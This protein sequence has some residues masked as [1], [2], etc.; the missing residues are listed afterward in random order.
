MA[1]G[2]EFRQV[3]E[4]LTTQQIEAVRVNNV[5]LVRRISL[6]ILIL[7]TDFT[8]EAAAA[9]VQ[10]LI[11]GT[12]EL[13][14]D[15]SDVLQNELK[16]GIVDSQLKIIRFGKEQF[17][18][19]LNDAFWKTLEYFFQNP[20]YKLDTMPLIQ[21][22]HFTNL[23]NIYNH[24]SGINKA[25]QQAGLAERGIRISKTGNAVGVYEL[26]FP[27]KR[28]VTEASSLPQ[29]QEQT[30]E[31]ISSKETKESQIT[32]LILI[33]T[34]VCDQN[35]QVL[36]DT[37]S[38]KRMAILR[39]LLERAETEVS[40]EELKEKLGYANQHDSNFSSIFSRLRTEIK[41]ASL[42]SRLIMISD[43]KRQVGTSRAEEK[44]YLLRILDPKVSIAL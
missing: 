18:L 1:T 34:T 27:G 3:I 30:S 22:G 23:S 40:R 35:H 5:E 15:F 17:R 29:V 25:L 39:Y 31:G 26:L 44:F 6:V 37:R 33:G 21:S 36:F 7:T 38:K 13:G 10:M 11:I 42:L 9:L 2:I 43:V 28:Y 41:D 20:N 16:V 12:P 4:L 32:Q 24:I 19:V 14:A 8:N